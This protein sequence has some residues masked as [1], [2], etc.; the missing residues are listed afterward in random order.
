MSARCVR[1]YYVW[2]YCART[3]CECALFVLIYFFVSIVLFYFCL[4]F[5]FLAFVVVVRVVCVSCVCKLC[6]RVL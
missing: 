5:L 1:A 3:H 4:L 2:E 6:V